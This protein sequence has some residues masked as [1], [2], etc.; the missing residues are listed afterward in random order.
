MK[1]QTV[2]ELASA[3]SANEDV[4]SITAKSGGAEV[5][6]SND[7]FFET[8]QTYEENEGIYKS[9]FCGVTFLTVVI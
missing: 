4:Y 9:V 6:L 2:L 7:A 3:V 8:F 1:I 5:L